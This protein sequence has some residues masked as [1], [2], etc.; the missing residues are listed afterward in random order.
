MFV[1]SFTVAFCLLYGVLIFLYPYFFTGATAWP[2]RR[3]NLFSLLAII[4]A[5]FVIFSLVLNVSDPILAN[6]LQHALGGG[7]MAFF[8]CFL[9]ATRS[10]IS[11][12]R[13]QFFCFSFLIVTA[14]GVANEVLEFFLQNYFGLHF[15]SAVND[16][17]LDL[18]SNVIG[19][20][21]ASIIFVPFVRKKAK[22]VEDN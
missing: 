17:W 14:L 19:A 3:A 1:L 7:F 12:S 20:L 16:T 2:G 10:A 21:V 9:A 18:I 5:T 22:V 4:V 6:R 13:F 8:V 11:L 15:A